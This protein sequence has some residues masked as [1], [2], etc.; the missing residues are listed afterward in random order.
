ME[1]KSHLRNSQVF[2][3]LGLPVCPSLSLSIWLL[4]VVFKI[5][6]FRLPFWGVQRDINFGKSG[7]TS[8]QLEDPRERGAGESLWVYT[9]L[10][11]G[12]K[13]WD[14]QPTR[15]WSGGGSVPQWKVMRCYFQWEEGSV[16]ETEV[17][18]VHPGQK[19]R[20]T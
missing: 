7:I 6:A 20:N 13:C 5:S 9:V 16:G 1:L 18:D 17:T 4:W 8:L 3:S 15:T 10:V 12:R 2:L 14:L 11:C 19:T